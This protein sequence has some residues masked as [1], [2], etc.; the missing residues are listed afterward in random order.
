MLRPL[1]VVLLCTRNT[2]GVQYATM[3]TGVT[4]AAKCCSSTPNSTQEDH[5]SSSCSACDDIMD[6]NQPNLDNSHGAEPAS[7]LDAG[8]AT[9]LVFFP[10]NDKTKIIGAPPAPL[11]ESN[12][13][14]EKQVGVCEKGPS[15]PGANPATH[16]PLEEEPVCATVLH[17][18]TDGPPGP[19]T[20]PAFHPISGAKPYRLLAS[21]PLMPDDAGHLHDGMRGCG[22]FAV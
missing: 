8:A 6:N 7:I 12:H 19:D 10:S 1:V 9:L 15:A 13:A 18:A 3:V 11:S 14:D 21:P 16:V 5:P 4:P 22:R 20:T 17:H 2:A